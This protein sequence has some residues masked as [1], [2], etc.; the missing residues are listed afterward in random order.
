MGKEV[1]VTYPKED[2]EATGDVWASEMQRKVGHLSHRR[3]RLW[4]GQEPIGLSPHLQ[5][6]CFWSRLRLDIIQ[7]REA[8]TPS[9]GYIVQ[10]TVRGGIHLQYKSWEENMHPKTRHTNEV[11]SS[12]T[13]M[14]T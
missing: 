7:V 2:A 12:L 10:V 6:P 8:C 9:D 13:L 1:G 4:Q 5:E 11:I 3:V 14:R